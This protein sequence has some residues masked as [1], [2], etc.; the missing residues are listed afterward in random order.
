MNGL[1]DVSATTIQTLSNQLQ[2]SR[3]SAG[4][5]Q[6]AATQATNARTSAN[7]RDQAAVMVAPF[8]DSTPG[9]ADPCLDPM[10]GQPMNCDEMGNAQRQLCSTC[11]PIG[12]SSS[13]GGSSSMP[14]FT[15]E[16]ALPT[17]VAGLLG[18]GVG[19]TLISMFVG[20]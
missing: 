15:V 4:V 2:R 10:T 20:K 16:G 17:A 7:I 1:G 14:S 13:Q 12:T 5:V 6:G 3:A 19:L 9:T 8:V 18:I 11:P